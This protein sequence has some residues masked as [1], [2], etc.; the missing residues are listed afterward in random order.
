M[1]SF[2]VRSVLSL[3]RPS[4]VP[5]AILPSLIL[6]CYASYRSLCHTIHSLRSRPLPLL[7]CFSASFPFFSPHFLV[8]RI[9]TRP[10]NSFS[11]LFSASRPRSFHPHPKSHV[12]HFSVLFSLFLPRPFLHRS[13]IPFPDS[14][15]LCFPLHPASFPLLFPP[16]FFCSTLHPHMFHLSSS[17]WLRIVSIFRVCLFLLYSSFSLLF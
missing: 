13:H 6:F 11:F 9:T 7:Y 8:R 10:F 5:S 2:F 4:R 3:S 17:S 14:L 16:P 1:P 15:P 12:F